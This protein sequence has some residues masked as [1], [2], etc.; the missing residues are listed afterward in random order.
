MI[1]TDSGVSLMIVSS[2]DRE[3]R[4]L[5]D[6]FTYIGGHE[7]QAI[8]VDVAW[9]VIQHSPPDA[10]IAL[11]TCDDH[12]RLFKAIREAFDTAAAPVLILATDHLPTEAFDD[13]LDA[14]TPPVGGHIDWHVRKALQRRAERIQQRREAEVLRAEVDELRRQ[15]KKAQELSDEVNL[16]KNAIV[17]N[18]SHELRTPLLQVKASVSMMAED[19][20]HPTLGKH[21]LA[22]TARLE[23]VVKNIT[24]LAQSMNDMQMV[25]MLV[26]ECVDYALLSLRQSWEHKDDVARVELHVEPQLPPALGDRHGISTVLHLLIDNALKF[27]ESTVEVHIQRVKDGIDIAVRDYGIGIPQDQLTAIF[28]AFYQVDSSS[29]RRYGGLGVGL[30]IVQMILDRHNAPIRVESE[31]GSGS[32]FSFKLPLANLPKHRD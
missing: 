31:V 13:L 17:R 12:Y 5:A 11:D 22:A 26:R 10:V 28:E 1:H 2:E 30:S 29:T 21:A 4:E 8:S 24:Q 14:V 32:T 23:G 19:V 20:K 27:S 15:L 25:P 9:D 7:V 18:V 3:A 16:L 6:Y